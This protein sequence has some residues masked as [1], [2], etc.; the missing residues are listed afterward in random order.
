MKG[1]GMSKCEKL[2]FLNNKMKAFTL[3]FRV[4]TAK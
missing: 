2:P 3:Y 1:R 4:I